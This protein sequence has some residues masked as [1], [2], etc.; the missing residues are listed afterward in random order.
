[1]KK[2]I[3]AANLGHVRV[4]K[5][6]EAGEDPIEQDHLIE[7]AE[8]SS[9]RHALSIQEVVTDQ[10]GRFARGNPVG[11]ETGM[12]YGQGNHLKAELERSAMKDIAG[13]I[14]DVLA[15]ENY[16][17]W[18]LA[19]PKPILPRLQEMLSSTARNTLA[20]TVGADLT[21]TPLPEM[22]QRFL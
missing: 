21:R 1:M 15:S 2:L 3:I 18:V 12:S 20:S 14:C 17:A 8:E 22:E 16:P 9:N 7:D 13:R 6:K 11:F 4:L 19:A 10:S 5:Y